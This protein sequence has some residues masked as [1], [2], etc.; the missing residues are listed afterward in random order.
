MNRAETLLPL[1]LALDESERIDLAL[2]LLESVEGAESDVERAWAPVV[3][4]RVQALR[5]GTAR[6]RP[7][8][9]AIDELRARLL[10]GRR[11]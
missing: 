3:A 4:A 2:R 9:D 8:A 6:T 10:A 5:A 7:M 11:A 1:A